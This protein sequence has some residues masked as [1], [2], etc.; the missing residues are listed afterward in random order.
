MEEKTEENGWMNEYREIE[1]IPFNVRKKRQKYNNVCGCVSR[2]NS[3]IQFSRMKE[4]IPHWST[5][6]SLHIFSMEIYIGFFACFFH[7]VN[8]SDFLGT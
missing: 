5:K 4:K 1:F 8:F 6:D 3:W 7:H 2:G